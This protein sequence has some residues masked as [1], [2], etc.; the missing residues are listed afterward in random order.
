MGQVPTRWVYLRNNKTKSL[1]INWLWGFFMWAHLESNQEHRNQNLVWYH[2]TMSQL[3]LVR[4]ENFEISTYRLK[5]GYSASELHPQ[6]LCRVGAPAPIVLILSHGPCLVLG[7]RIEL[8]FPPWKG[9]VL[10]D[11]RTEQNLK[12]HNYCCL[13]VGR[14]SCPA[15]HSPF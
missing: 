8:V 9:S 12:G 14:F 6:N 4:V 11:R 2:F 1:I 5:A 13:R 10:T 7:T 15:K 3:K